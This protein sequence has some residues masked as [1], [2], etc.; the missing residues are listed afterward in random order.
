MADAVTVFV[1]MT[2]KSFLNGNVGVYEIFKKYKN[3]KKYAFKAE[4]I[5]LHPKLQ[6]KEVVF[7]GKNSQTDL[8]NFHF[9][10]S[11]PPQTL[12]SSSWKGRWSLAPLYLRFV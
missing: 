2:E 8:H 7:Q 11:L 6:T 5:F 9:R 10:Y 4:K 12:L 3:N 1:G